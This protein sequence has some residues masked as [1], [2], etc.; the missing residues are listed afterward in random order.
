IEKIKN[1]AA[2]TV[3]EIKSTGATEVESIQREIEAEVAELVKTHASTLEKTKA[4]MELVAV[5]KAK[6]AGNIAVQS[7][8]RAQID[9]IFNAVAEDLQSHSPD[10]YVAFFQ[11]YVTEIVPKDAEV[12]HVQAPAKREEETNKILKGAGFAGVVKADPVIKAGLVIHTKDG[13]Y[14]VTLAR[15]MNEKRDE[16]EMIIVN[17]VMA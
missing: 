16:L 7:A 12:D 11:K 10:E 4:Q 3:A 9:A 1:D 8:K 15:L 17:Q 14:D 6:Q 2:K 13:V 5:S